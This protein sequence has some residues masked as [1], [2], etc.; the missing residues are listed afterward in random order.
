MW[1]AKRDGNIDVDVIFNIGDQYLCGLPGTLGN[2]TRCIDIGVN[3]TLTTE[4]QSPVK[5]V[6]FIEKV[7]Q[8]CFT[9]L[10]CNST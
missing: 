9:F 2:D 3:H 1:Q 7:G 6:L 8:N 4:G 5:V 10:T